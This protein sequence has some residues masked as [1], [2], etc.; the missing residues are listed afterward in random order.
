MR[1][2]DWGGGG[3]ST[4]IPF[5]CCSCFPREAKQVGMIMMN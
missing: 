5:C 1:E 2:K 3:G 4:K